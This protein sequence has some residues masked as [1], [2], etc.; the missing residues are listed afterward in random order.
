MAL[1]EDFDGEALYQP[2]AW[3]LHELLEVDV[4]QRRVV[5]AMDTTALSLLVDAQRVVSGHERHVPAAAIIQ[6][7]GTLGQLYV[8][9]GLG[10]RASAGWHGYGTHI[11]QARFARMGRIGP[12]IRATAVCTRQR[13]MM[14]TWFCDFDIRFEQEGEA[15]YTSTQSAVWRRQERGG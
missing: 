3:F 4:E 7:T 2:W 11:R 14:G 9:Y 6:A 13:Q 8:V 15:V 1:P 12:P 10:L 5:A